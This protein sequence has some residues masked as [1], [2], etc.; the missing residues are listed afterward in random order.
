MRDNLVSWLLECGEPWTRYRTLVD[1]ERLEESAPEVVSAREAMI[2]HPAIKQLVDSANTWPGYGLKRHNDAKHPLHQI[3][4]LADFGLLA[5]DPGMDALISKLMEHQDSLGPFQTLSHLYKRFA[6][7]EG[8]N[9]TWMMCDAPTVLYALARFGMGGDPRVYK[10]LDH[11]KSIVRDNGWSCA[12]GDPMRPTF[13]GPGRRE[14]PCPYANLIA[15]KALA[16]LE[17]DRESGA[18][19]AGLEVLLRHWDRSYERKL[20]LFASGSGFRKLKYPHVWYDILHVAE[21]LSLF[22]SIHDDRRFKS[23]LGELEGQAD[24]DGR[25]TA[26][27]MYQAWKS[28]SFADKKKP[29]PWLTFLVMR[30]LKRANGDH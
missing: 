4:T 17:P 11:M 22:P 15:L 23:M 25:Y 24:E 16:S 2:Q 14:D 13:K 18:I 26:S 20:F 3:S 30:I 29:S 5:G 19:N 27:S 7:V 1:L 21:V 28:W 9:W 12:A 8:E 10:A 6:G